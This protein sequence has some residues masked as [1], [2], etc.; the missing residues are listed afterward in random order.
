MQQL[1]SSRAAALGLLGLVALPGLF[2]LPRAAAAAP[3][4]S[5]GS[6][7]EISSSK[8]WTAYSYAEKDGLV[9]YLVGYPSKVE[10]AAAGK[11]RVDAIVTHRTQDKSAYVV[12]FDVGYPF[13]PGSNAA[14]DIDGHKFTLFVDKETAWAPDAATDKAV[15]AA[16]A[17]GKSASLKGTP[18][19][20]APTTD[21]YELAGFGEALAAIDKTCNIK[22]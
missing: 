19:K 4:P 17:K 14:L 1:I 3:A 10:P 18:E 7:K 15:T 12:N 22:R 5:A 6:P 20:G 11:R 8:G 16:L 13:K 21:I 2:A 9:C